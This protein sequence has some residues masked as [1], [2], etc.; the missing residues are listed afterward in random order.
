MTAPT[1]PDEFPP[2]PNG[3]GG[4]WLMNPV[5]LEQTPVVDEPTPEDE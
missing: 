3:A 4:L 5:T 1:P 2:P